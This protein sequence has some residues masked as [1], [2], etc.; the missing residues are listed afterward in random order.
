[1][2]VTGEGIGQVRFYSFCSQELAW[3]HFNDEWT[4]RVVLDELGG[5]KA[6]A[7]HCLALQTIRKQFGVSPCNNTNGFRQPW[8]VE[9]NV[10]VLHNPKLNQF[11]RVMG[12]V[13]DA[14]GGKW[15]IEDHK[16]SECF[17]LVDGGHGEFGLHRCIATRKRFAHDRRNC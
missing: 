1:M 2:V 6:E 8:L 11:I 10:I 3:R 5:V 15:N 12:D 17:R 7:G 14:R 9:G 16:S 4:A 13:V